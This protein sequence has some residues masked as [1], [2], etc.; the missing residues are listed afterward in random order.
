MIIKS[1]IIAVRYTRNHEIKIYFV[2]NKDLN[3]FGQ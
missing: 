1:E 3:I 2:K